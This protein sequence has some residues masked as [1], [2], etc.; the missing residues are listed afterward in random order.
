MMIKRI[1]VFVYL[2][3]FS[4]LALTGQVHSPNLLW[5]DISGQ[6]ER[7]VVVAQGTPEL[8]NGHVTTVL[9]DDGKTMV[10][11]WSREHGGAADFLAFSH[12]GGLTWDK[13]DAPEEW[14]GLVCCPS[15]YKLT[16]KKGKQRLFV[17][18]L[19][20]NGPGKYLANWGDPSRDHRKMAYSYSEDGG[21][22]WSKLVL[23]PWSNDENWNPESPFVYCIMPFTSIIR[24]KNGDYLAMYGTRQSYEERV[25]GKICQAVSHDGGLTWETG[26]IVGESSGRALG[27]PCLLRSPDGNTL[28]CVTRENNRIGNSMM[29][30]SDDEGKTWSPMRETPWGLT[31]DRHQMV[32]IPDTFPPR[33]PM[34][35]RIIAVFRDMALG[36]PTKGHFVA[37][38]G[39]WGDILEGRSG[40]YKVKLLHSFNNFDCGYP[41]LEVLP[42]GTIVA[43]TYIKYHPGPELNSIVS[44][45]FKID[46]LDALFQ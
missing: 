12:D 17:F 45:R 43:T 40:Q 39:T 42:D 29:M 33:G 41:G 27:E 8:Y 10:A 26:R 18:G 6:S 31:G 24:L 5:T 11:V 28:L 1:I 38:V 34:Y 3:L 16:D 46:E 37:W 19:R 14:Y 22:T 21:K 44:V 25:P 9:L 32:Y 7:Q 20:H 23:I 35:T 36:S 15:I 4:T 13:K 2:G 30:T